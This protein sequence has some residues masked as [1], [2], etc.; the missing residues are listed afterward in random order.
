LTF[1]DL[2]PQQS[3]EL[4][5]EV[6]GSLGDAVQPV[7]ISAALEAG[8]HRIR[9]VLDAG[10]ENEPKSNLGDGAPLLL[11]EGPGILPAT[12]PPGALAH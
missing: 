4:R 3:P 10:I 12:V 2:P 7:R 9:I 5:I 1:D 8:W 11:W 6:C